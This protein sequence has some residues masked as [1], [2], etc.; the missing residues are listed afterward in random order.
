MG[1]RKDPA[2]MQVDTRALGWLTESRALVL[3]GQM[4]PGGLLH[5]VFTAGKQQESKE[6]KETRCRSAGGPSQDC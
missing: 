5:N 6:S 1:L 4:L 2:E 3:P